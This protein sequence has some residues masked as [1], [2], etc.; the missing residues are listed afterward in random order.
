MRSAAFAVNDDSAEMG[1]SD[2]THGT[3]LH[4]LRF[5]AG[6]YAHDPAANR[7]LDSFVCIWW[8][9]WTLPPSRWYIHEFAPSFCSVAGRD[10]AAERTL[11]E[12]SRAYV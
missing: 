10:R 4:S 11:I 8:G 3:S 5:D 6:E 9:C 2:D 1:S 7:D 12:R